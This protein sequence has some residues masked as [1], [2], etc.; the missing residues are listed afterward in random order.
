[1][2]NRNYI[3]Q[4]DFLLNLLKWCLDPIRMLNPSFSQKQVRLKFCKFNLCVSSAAE[5]FCVISK[6]NPNMKNAE[7]LWD[8][9]VCQVD[10]IF[11]VISYQI[12][13]ITNVCRTD[14]LMGFWESGWDP[15]REKKK[16]TKTH[17]EDEDFKIIRHIITSFRTLSNP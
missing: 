8:V 15:F 17:P 13:F 4:T 1:M 11:W 12:H 10:I 6:T 5:T 16:K 3:F 9:D 14:V 7:T 2:N